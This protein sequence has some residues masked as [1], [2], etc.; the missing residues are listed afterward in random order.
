MTLTYICDI[1]IHVKENFPNQA[2]GAGFFRDTSG[3][4]APAVAFSSTANLSIAS[5]IWS[6]EGFPRNRDFFV[7]LTVFEI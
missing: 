5:Y 3:P 2:L 1:G 4:R 6:A 7:R